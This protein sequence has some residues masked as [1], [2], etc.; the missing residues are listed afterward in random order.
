M[1]AFDET[2]V[3]RMIQVI[4]NGQP[5]WRQMEELREIAGDA[6]EYRGLSAVSFDGTDECV[7][8]A[9]KL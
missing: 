2:I 3:D 4:D 1:S 5:E 7:G 9:C 6:R 8:G